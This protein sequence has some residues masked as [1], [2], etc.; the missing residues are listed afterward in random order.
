MHKQ[1]RDTLNVLFGKT[2]SKLAIFREGI[3]K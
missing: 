2:N 1:Y 3:G